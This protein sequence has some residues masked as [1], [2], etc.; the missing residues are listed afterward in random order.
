MRATFTASAVTRVSARVYVEYDFRIVLNE[1][2]DQMAIVKAV[3]RN[4]SG[5]A[6]R[7]VCMEIYVVSLS[8]SR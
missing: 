1:T 4:R 5:N 8:L 2:Q 3:T 6:Y 7:F